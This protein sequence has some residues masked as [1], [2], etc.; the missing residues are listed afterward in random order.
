[1][2]LTFLLTQ[3]LDSPGGGGRHLPLAKALARLGHRPRLIALHHDYRHAAER[4]YLDD[5][6]QVHYVGQMHV[7]KAGN[8][9]TYYRAPALL[10]VAALGTARLA[11]AALRWPGDALHVC[12]T[13]P[14]NAAAAWLAHRLRG[15]PVYLDSDDYETI[16]NRFSSPWQQQVVRRFEDWM[17]S[18]AAGITAS[19]T[20]IAQRFASLGYPPDRIRV[21]PHGIDPARFAV[22]EQ[23]GLEDRLAGLRRRLDIGPDDP[24]VVY[25]GSLSLV[26]HALELLVRAFADVAEAEPRAR[27]LLVGAGEDLERL[28]VM[29]D[30]AGLRPR[31]RFAG[32]VPKEEVPLYFRLGRV[33]ADPKRDTPAAHSSLSLKMIESIACGVPCV[34][35][36]TG[37]SKA[38]LDGAGLAVRPGDAAALAE[39]LLAILRDPDRAAGMRTAAAALRQE[40]SW[41]ALARRFAGIYQLAGPP[42]AGTA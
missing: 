10:A 24:V 14:M 39:G 22:L 42:A 38:L 19:N 20:F 11:A 15:V 33:S 18:F 36:D 12:K 7:R 25:V 26:N 9:K 32:R 1:M 4:R 29:V 23:A 13:Q 5:G 2:R 28:Q 34:T 41:D 40:Y 8:R 30:E 31:A 17:P 6:V 3:S 35:A 21:I 16:N 27:L 37:D